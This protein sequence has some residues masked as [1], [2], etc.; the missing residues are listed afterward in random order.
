MQLVGVD[1]ETE[2]L[3][4][5]LRWI[6]ARLLEAKLFLANIESIEDGVDIIIGNATVL[7]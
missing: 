3:R 4:S 1:Q 6:K 7:P 5:N 2:S